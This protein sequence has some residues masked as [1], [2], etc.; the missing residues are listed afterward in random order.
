[1]RFALNE[2]LIFIVSL[3]LFQSSNGSDLISKNCKEASNRDPGIMY[4]FCVACLE[5]AS[6]KLHP[7]PTNLEDLLGI[8]ITI[9]KNNATNVL[10]IISKLSKDKSLDKFALLTLQECSRLYDQSVFFLDQIAGTLKSKVFD[11]VGMDLSGI[12]TF[13]R[14]CNEDLS[15]KWRGGISPLSKE[16]QIFDQ[17]IWISHVFFE[18]ITKT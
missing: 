4:D 17:L 11:Y 14:V 8:L 16:Y 5:E 2:S 1:M 15:S 9:S 12:G 6:S 10:S 7:P 18:I 3:F 13:A